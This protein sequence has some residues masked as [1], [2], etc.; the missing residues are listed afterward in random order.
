MTGFCA[1]ASSKLHGHFAEDKTVAAAAP[2]PKAA[3]AATLCSS[4]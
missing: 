2:P 3:T 1:K 4:D